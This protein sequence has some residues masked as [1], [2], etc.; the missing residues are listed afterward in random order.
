M[1]SSEQIVERLRKYF[2]ERPDLAVASAYLFGSQAEGRAHRESDIDVAVL[3]Q[4]D[5]YPIRDNRD[6]ARNRLGSELITI[7]HHSKV[8]VVILNDAPPLFGRQII[9]DGIRAYLGDPAKDHNY[10]RD[11][12]IMAAD[13]EPWLKSRGQI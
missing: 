12:Q 5:R 11:V 3:L 13:L 8:D 4:W 9:Y 1:S 7:L 6:D 10:V 2:E